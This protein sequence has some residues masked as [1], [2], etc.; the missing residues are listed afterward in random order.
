MSRFLV[1]TLAL[2]AAGCSFE[3]RP[4][5]TTTFHS[6]SE[7]F[8]EDDTQADPLGDAVEPV[9]VSDA[10]TTAGSAPA[11]TTED[12][13]SEVEETPTSESDQ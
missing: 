2:A 13:S 5:A 10:D 8:Y 11:E 7:G 1:L 4:D 6:T 12:L 9:S 3:D